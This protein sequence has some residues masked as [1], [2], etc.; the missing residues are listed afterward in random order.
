M[1]RSESTSKSV[2][3]KPKKKNDNEKK[4]KKVH[5]DPV[6]EAIEFADEEPDEEKE[7]P[8]SSFNNVIPTIEGD[9]LAESFSLTPLTPNP[10]TELNQEV[11]SKPKDLSQINEQKNDASANLDSKN[12]KEDKPPCFDDFELLRLIG[13][14]SFAK[15]LL[16]RKKDNGKLYAMKVLKKEE[17]FK[18]NQI[19][20]TKTERIILATLRH[21]FM[22]RLRYSFQTENKLYMVLDFVRGGE[23]FY[24]LRKA[25]RFSEERARFYISEVILALDYLHRHDVIYRDLKPENI[26]LSEDGHI[27]LTDFG[28]SKKG[29]TSVGGKGEGQTATTFCGTPEYLAPEIITGIGHGK[30]VDWWSVGILLYEM[31]T[32][33]PP[34][35]SKNRNQLYINTIKGNIKWPEGM[36]ENA[37]DLLQKLLHR[38]PEERLGSKGV[39]D[40]KAH[41]FFKGLDWDKV[42]SKQIKPE[43][44][45]VCIDE[46]WDLSSPEFNDPVME[47]M[48]EA[49]DLEYDEKAKVEFPD[50]TFADNSP[51]DSKIDNDKVGVVS[52]K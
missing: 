32:G 12:V 30:A 45:P 23:L 17:I 36:S 52:R 6:I 38:K 3:K 50:F 34:F 9:D 35:S 4:K 24:H 47:W 48:N 10:I 39:N 49:D 16:V 51:I 18:R 22:V 27:K 46:D 44:I 40:I 13:T 43:F 26:L 21:P 41:P 11:R 37:K 2:S 33:R 20:H 7:N 8:S 19:D 31:L 14:G 42:I 5:L 28:L 25:G 15:V 1:K 29:I